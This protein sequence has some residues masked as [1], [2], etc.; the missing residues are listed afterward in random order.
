[1]VMV[2]FLFIG[3]PS[4]HPPHK[5]VIEYQKIVITDSELRDCETEAAAHDRLEMLLDLTPRSGLFCIGGDLGY[6]ND[7]TE[8]VIFQE[9]EIGER[10]R[11]KMI[12]RLKGPRKN[13]FPFYASRLQA[14]FVRS[15]GHKILKRACSSSGLRP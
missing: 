7:P 11:L 2:G 12:L 10:S 1:M 3:L 9:M 5:K 15:Q 4:V 14:I 13:N 6:T 8:I